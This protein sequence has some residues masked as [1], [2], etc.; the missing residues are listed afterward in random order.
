MYCV[1]SAQVNAVHTTPGS[2]QL[3][4]TSVA[5]S[6]TRKK[7]RA[8]GVVL[9]DW[10]LEKINAEADGYGTVELGKALAIAVGRPTPWDHSA[11]SRF[12]RDEVTTAPMADAFAMLFDLPKPVYQASSFAEADELRRAAKK[13]A[14]PAAVSQEQERRL[15][16]VDQLRDVE[17]E[18]DS[19]QTSPVDSQDERARGSRRSRRTARRGPS[20]S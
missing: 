12:L 20:T 5:Q 2:V 15:A 18:R 14:S 10:F 11:V 19:D 16:A 17:E 13:H 6:S 9:P 3:V 1:L 8:K 4:S 7:K